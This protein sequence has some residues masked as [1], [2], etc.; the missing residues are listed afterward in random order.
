RVS[1][2]D[3]EA[4]LRERPAAEGSVATTGPE[5]TIDRAPATPEAR[6]A[7]PAHPPSA[8]GGDTRITASPMRRTIAQRMAQSAREIPHAWLMVEVDVT[9]LVQLREGIKERFRQTEG[10]EI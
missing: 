9:R 10:V 8:D 4:Y 5:L 2:D 1:R 6:A 7:T 3:V